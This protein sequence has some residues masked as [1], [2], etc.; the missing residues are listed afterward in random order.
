MSEQANVF[1]GGRLISGLKRF[2]LASQIVVRCAGRD[3]MISSPHLNKLL[4]QSIG[5]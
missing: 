3:D 2:K 5:H 1:E 4:H